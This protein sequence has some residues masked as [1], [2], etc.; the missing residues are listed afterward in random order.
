MAVS[1]GRAIVCR[2]DASPESVGF[3]NIENIA[4]VGARGPVTP[5][6]S[7]WTKRIPIVVNTDIQSGVANYTEQ[8]S[9]Y[10][11]ENRTESLTCLDPAPRWAIVPELGLVSFGSSTDEARIIADIARHTAKVIQQSEALGGWR[12]LPARDVFQVEYWELEQAKLSQ[13]ETAL[14]LQGKIALVTGAASGIGKAVAQQLRNDGAAVLAT[15]HQSQR[16]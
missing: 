7:I 6:H 14:P 16:P 9:R 2:W 1:R 3:A 13:R 10:F 11:E 12:A 15:G 4:D 5:D 8:Y